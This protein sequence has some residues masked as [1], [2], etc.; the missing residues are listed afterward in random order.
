MDVS[1]TGAPARARHAVAAP[2]EA[3][4]MLVQPRDRIA[5]LAAGSEGPAALIKRVDA[6]TSADRQW[7]LDGA[8]ALLAQRAEGARPPF[9][10][11]ELN[12]VLLG[13]LVGSLTQRT[14]THSDAVVFATALVQLNALAR[15]RHG[16][17]VFQTATYKVDP[18]FI[19]EN[20]NLGALSILAADCQLARGGAAVLRV[21]VRGR[22]T[23][24]LY[25][26]GKLPG[27]GC[28]QAQPEG[29][30]ALSERLMLGMFVA[31]GDLEGSAIQHGKVLQH[32]AGLAAARS[33]AVT[34]GLGRLQQAP[35]HPALYGV[36][37]RSQRDPQ[38]SAANTTPAQLARMLDAIVAHR[39]GKSGNAAIVLFGDRPS[40]ELLPVIGKHR[41][42]L[43]VFDLVET[44]Q[45]KWG[46]GHGTALD[47]REQAVLY[48][49]LASDYSLLAIVGNKSGAMDL[50]AHVGVPT[51]Q[52]GPLAEG[53]DPLANRIGLLSLVSDSWTF[54]P[55]PARAGEGASATALPV[56]DD[57][58]SQIVAGLDRAWL[59]ASR[60]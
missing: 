1:H 49:T 14:G 35:R 36:M 47:L 29:L 6:L 33:A 17:D 50:P 44:W 22:Q 11:A 52:V 15:R 45:P 26:F 18:S 4:A 28:G 60:G 3:P 54:I 34:S 38:R 40:S 48:A 37:I 13:R 43:A 57:A 20:A 59:R 51:L 19:G 2:A 55:E 41:A 10:R 53:A 23:H 30:H 58:W 24:P 16:E 31:D 39:S 21:E 25:A 27:N 32:Y 9:D 56:R 12:L 8:A 46:N 5:E 42:D 7:V